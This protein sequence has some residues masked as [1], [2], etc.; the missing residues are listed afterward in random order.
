MHSVFQPPDLLSAYHIKPSLKVFLQKEKLFCNL[1]KRGC[2]Q[3][4]MQKCRLMYKKSVDVCFLN[5]HFFVD[6]CRW[7]C[8]VCFDGV[9]H[10]ELS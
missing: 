3:K 1:L 7:L 8:V 9:G 10:G 6:E 5:V 2:L 4:M